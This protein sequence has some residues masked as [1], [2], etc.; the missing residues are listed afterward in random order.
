MARGAAPSKEEFRLEMSG[1]NERR[2]SVR[3]NFSWVRYGSGDPETPNLDKSGHLGS[4]KNG[5][6]KIA[7][8]WHEPSLTPKLP[9]GMVVD[10][11]KI[12]RG[13]P[14][15]SKNGPKNADFSKSK[16][17]NF[18]RSKIQ[19]RVGITKLEQNP[20]ILRGP[21][22]LKTLKIEGGQNFNL[23]KVGLSYTQMKG[24]DEHFQDL[25]LVLAYD[26]I[27]AS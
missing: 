6:K 27:M 24:L 2:N 22:P 4:R 17:Q 20:T 23:S 8:I 5:S 13:A 1:A 9:W 10:P 11:P 15:G 18:F 3:P 14:G 19:R 21:K 26:V 16:F 7:Q 25:T 12:S